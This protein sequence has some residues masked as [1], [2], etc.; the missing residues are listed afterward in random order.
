MGSSTNLA[1]YL[2]TVLGMDSVRATMLINIFNGSAALA[3]LAGAFL[4][5]AYFGR[6]RTMGFACVTSFLVLNL[7]F[8]TCSC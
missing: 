4:S 5:D 6:Y 8:I 3:I 7:A 2:T 1:A